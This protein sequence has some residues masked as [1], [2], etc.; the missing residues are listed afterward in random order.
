MIKVLF[1]CTYGKF[2]SENIPLACNMD[3]EVMSLPNEVSLLCVLLVTEE[4]LQVTSAGHVHWWSWSYG[5]VLLE[6]LA[7]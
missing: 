6:V 5:C 3:C 1:V 4:V 2:P 7:G